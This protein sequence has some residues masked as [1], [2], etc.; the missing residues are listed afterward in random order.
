VYS[1]KGYGGSYNAQPSIYRYANW[2]LFSCHSKFHHLTQN[3]GLFK[4]VT[5]QFIGQQRLMNQA[6]KKCPLLTV[7]SEFYIIYLHIHIFN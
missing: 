6:T 7:K 1:E 5:D 2:S 3:L 4:N